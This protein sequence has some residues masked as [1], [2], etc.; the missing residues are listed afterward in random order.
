MKIGGNGVVLHQ[1]YAAISD[2][3]TFFEREVAA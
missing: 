1:A 2:A 3:L